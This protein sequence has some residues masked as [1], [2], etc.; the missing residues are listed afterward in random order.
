MGDKA[1]DGKGPVTAVGRLKVMLS[2][3]EL[4]VVDNVE[5]LLTSAY[6]DEACPIAVSFTWCLG[7][8]T[9]YVGHSDRFTKYLCF[10]AAKFDSN[11]RD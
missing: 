5:S 6:C 7:C 10:E 11:I 4:L 3:R 9:A 1:E 2:H 8:P